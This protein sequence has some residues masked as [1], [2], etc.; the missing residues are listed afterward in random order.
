MAWQGHGE[1]NMTGKRIG[2]VRVST[3][4]QNTERQ[5]EGLQ[6]DRKFEDKVSGKDRD[7]P[8]LKELIAYCRDGDTVYAHSLDRLGR[9]M[10]DLLEIVDELN[11]KGVTVEFVKEKLS[12]T[13]GDGS[14]F[15]RF[16]LQ[17]FAAVAEFERAM[18]RERQREG[19]ALARQRCAFKGRER[20]LTDEQV[21]LLIDRIEGDGIPL[22]KVARDLGFLGIKSAKGQLRTKVARQTL[23]M[24]R[25]Q[26]IQ[27]HPEI[28]AK[29]PRL[30]R[31]IKQETAVA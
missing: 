25:E 2:Y 6:L 19:I 30:K 14:P 29:Y 16:Q 31:L 27:K 1:E 9:N 26:Y 11:T 13:P 18:I 21:A 24:E 22:A 10:R 23:F 15:S 17:I 8:A 12:F 20:I 7:R 5:L 28:L 4:V 3:V